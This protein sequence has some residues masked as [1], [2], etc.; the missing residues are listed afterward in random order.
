[1]KVS[2]DDET[3]LMRGWG[4][5]CRLQMMDSLVCPWYVCSQEMSTQDAP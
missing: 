3:K 5:P 1:M 2:L 4:L